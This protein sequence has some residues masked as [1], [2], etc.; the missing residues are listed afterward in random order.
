[1]IC[2]DKKYKECIFVFVR[3]ILNAEEIAINISVKNDVKKQ[4]KEAFGDILKFEE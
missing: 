4:A 2:E 1:M 3:E